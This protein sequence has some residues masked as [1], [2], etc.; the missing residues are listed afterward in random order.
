M[1]AVRARGGP[2]TK[3]QRFA[4][5]IRQHR[6]NSSHLEIDDM[7]TPAYGDPDFDEAKFPNASDMFRRLRD[8]GFRVTLW[9]HPFINYNSS[10]W[11][12]VK[13]VCARTH[14]PAAGSRALVE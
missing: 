3:L 9:V 7:Y 5:Q 8:A 6:F 2:G 4:Q 12:G 11:R 10:R 14:R 13:A 1:G